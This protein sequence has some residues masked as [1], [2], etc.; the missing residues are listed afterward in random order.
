VASNFTARDSDRRDKP[1]RR[2]DLIGAIVIIRWKGSDSTIKLRYMRD[3]VL[4]I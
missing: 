1:A 4:L 2:T 3:N